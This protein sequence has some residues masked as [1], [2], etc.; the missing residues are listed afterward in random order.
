MPNGLQKRCLAWILRKGLQSGTIDPFKRVL[1]DQNGAVVSSET[2]EWIALEVP[3]EAP[4][5][6]I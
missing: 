3:F 2:H 1:I 5:A 4:K 6:S